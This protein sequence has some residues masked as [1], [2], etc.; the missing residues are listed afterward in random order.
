MGQLRSFRK[1]CRPAKTSLFLVTAGRTGN[2]LL[3]KSLHSPGELLAVKCGRKNLPLFTVFEVFCQYIWSGPS[4][5]DLHACNLQVMYMNEIMWTANSSHNIMNLTLH[6]NIRTHNMTCFQSAPAVINQLVEPQFF[7][8]L[9]NWQYICEDHF[10]TLCTWYDI[11][12]WWV[13]GVKLCSSIPFTNSSL[14]G[15]VCRS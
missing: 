7:L 5:P 12:N 3:Q 10:F 9:L 1:Y 8:L 6:W 11:V 13:L 4:W 15:T 2:K 14:Y